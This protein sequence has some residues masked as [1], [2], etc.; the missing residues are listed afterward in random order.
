MMSSGCFKVAFSLLAVFAV[1]PAMGQN[2]TN[3]ASA[4]KEGS[5]VELRMVKFTGDDGYP[6]YE[7]VDP[8]GP[9]GDAKVSIRCIDNGYD[10]NA[11]GKTVSWKYHELMVFDSEKG[12]EI[13]RKE[14]R[15]NVASEKGW[16]FKFKNFDECE[17]AAPNASDANCTMTVKLSRSRG[18]ASLVSAGC[19]PIEATK[20]STGGSSVPSKPTIR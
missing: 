8:N 3:K 16:N 10:V 14:P 1:L 17:K 15:G 2:S 5:V 11:Q 9:M 7:T 13:K 4:M 19:K 20:P 6:L 12:R 18:L